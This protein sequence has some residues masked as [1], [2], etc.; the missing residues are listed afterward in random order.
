MDILWLLNEHI[1]NIQTKN[2][3][4]DFVHNSDSIDENGLLY[5]YQ[6][7]FRYCYIY[8]VSTQVN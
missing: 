1:N 4:S 5:Y 6:K 8:Y 3:L 7:N 2:I